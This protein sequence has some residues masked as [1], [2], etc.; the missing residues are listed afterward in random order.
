VEKAP[1]NCILC[2][3]TGREILF[4]Q[5]DWTV[6][7]CVD[8]GL[9]ILDPRPGDDELKSF[10]ERKYFNKH[11]GSGLAVDSPEMKRR[12]SQE[13]HRVRFFRR[14][15]K[16][17]RI[18]DIGCGMG[19]FLHACRLRGYEVEGMD[20]SDDSADYVRSVL[21]I[22]VRTGKAE[23]LEYEAGSFDIITMWH[24]LEHMPAPRVYLCKARKWLKPDGLLVIDVPNH[25]GTDAKKT[26]Q[27]WPGWDLPF[28]LFHFNYATVDRLLENNG[29]RVIRKKDYLSEYVKQRIE[30][31]PLL[32]PFARPVARL[33]S[34]H[35]YAV[36]AEK[37]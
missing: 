25:E 1:D 23:T 13:T 2:G 18:L 6:F 11:Y 19:Y 21:Q 5:G 28:H 10:Y 20:I 24:S 15:K 22:K 36:V 8:C 35:S 7:R 29:F 9:G 16:T 27:T 34:G 30:R 31:I 37:S 12:L 33:Y 4:R 14:F 32:K 17:G 3:G 26:W